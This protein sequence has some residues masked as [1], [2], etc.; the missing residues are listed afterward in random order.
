METQTEVK[1]PAVPEAGEPTVA[2]LQ[3]SIA[4]RVVALAGLSAPIDATAAN[5]ARYMN[6]RSALETILETLVREG[7]ICGGMFIG[8]APGAPGT[9]PFMPVSARAGDIG[10][11]TGQVALAIAALPQD[12]LIKAERV[13]EL[14]VAAGTVSSVEAPAAEPAARS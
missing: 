8:T 7:V 10:I 1:A 12:E 2:Q 11:T 9:I 3:A 14:L 6:A 4:E 5:A 13:A